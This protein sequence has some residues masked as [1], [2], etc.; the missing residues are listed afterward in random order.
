VPRVTLVHDY[1]TQ[2]GGAERVVLELLRAF[3]GAVLH[4]ALW[5]P[6][7]TFP[8][9]ADHDV[10]VSPLDRVPGLR[11]DHRRALPLLARTFDRMPL[12]PSDVVVCS[13]SGWAHG[14]RTGDRPKVVYCHT[15]ARW[16][17]A[18][19]RGRTVGGRAGGA[20]M[21]L[22]R[23]PLLSWDLR[24]AGSAHSYLANSSVVRERIGSAYGR[25]AEIVAPPP[26]LL[27]D[28]P[29]EDPGDLAPG[30]F[31]V[32]ARL[33]PYKNVDV[34]VRAT[35][36]LPGA[37]LV[38]VGDGPQRAR[39]QHLAGDGVVFRAGVSD[40]ELRWLYRS[41]AALVT[42]SHEDFGLTPLE[43]NAFGRP[44]VAL[45]AGGHL[46]T[47]EPGRSGLFVEELDPRSFADAMRRC[48]DT[49]WSE[50]HL[51][52]HAERFSRE[53][54]DAVLREIVASAAGDAPSSAREDVGP[55]Q[56][57]P[58]EDGVAEQ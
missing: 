43:A 41:A 44:V 33:L 21:A 57:T 38:V 53:R 31:L 47:V 56:P 58:G 25:Q 14:V 42:A 1:L 11:A 23:R 32:V 17:H 35:A 37:R 46:D 18:P 15:P 55:A 27:P 40:A 54:F 10:R 8:E 6:D 51:R 30:F 26:G 22:L 28:G 7:R 5:D 50:K 34:V 4:T 16:L 49:V 3:P 45:R 29:E 24:A 20:A 39:L 2:R 36:L 9:F 52:A 13:S 19:S 12:A 48:A